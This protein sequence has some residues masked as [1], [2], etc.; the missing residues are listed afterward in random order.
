MPVSRFCKIFILFIVIFSSCKKE[1]NDNKQQY[2]EEKKIE[3][4]VNI[5][6]NIAEQLAFLFENKT[7]EIF[8][9]S[10]PNSVFIENA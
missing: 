6:D 8:F 2:T 7:T 10:S 4:I 5:E 1:S 9:N 3:V